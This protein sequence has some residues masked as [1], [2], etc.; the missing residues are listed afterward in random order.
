LDFNGGIK[1]CDFGMARLRQHTYVSTQNIAGSPSWMAPEVLRGDDFDCSS[2]VY[3]FGVI[4]WEVLTCEIPWVDKSMAQL[5]GLVGFQRAQLEVPKRLPNGCPPDYV[6]VMQQCWAD[7]P[8]RPT[9]SGLWKLL[10]NMI[11]ADAV[12]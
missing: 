8:Q 1:V 5:V 11:V 9:F 7:P 3:A 12:D 10:D 2:D 6:S 4:M